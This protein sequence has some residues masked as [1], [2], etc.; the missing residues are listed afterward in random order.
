MSKI[1][2]LDTIGGFNT[3]DIK[4]FNKRGKK[5]EN[6]S[7]NKLRESIL[8]D[9]LNL[10]LD[11]ID[12]ECTDK[13]EWLYIQKKWREVLMSLI[14]VEAGTGDPEPE[15]YPEKE[16][17]ENN[18]EIKINVKQKAGRQHNYDFLVDYKIKNKVLFTRKVEFKYNCSKL[19]NMPQFIQLP[20]TTDMFETGKISYSE[21]Y[22]DNYLSEY[23]ETDKNLKL[24]IEKSDYLKHIKKVDRGCH[25][26][27]DMLYKHYDINKHKKEDI[28]N[29]SI[30]DFLEKYSDKLDIDWLSEKINTSQKDKYYVISL[31]IKEINI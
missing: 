7:D 18:Q 11:E 26:F 9:I 15:P 8:E 2:F 25:S 19:K 22:F 4:I 20:D 12:D 23:I 10:N 5:E 13:E 29:K 30:K 1:T 28:I 3:S 6:D 27:F 17:I 21:F 14:D 31:N 16:I 24:N